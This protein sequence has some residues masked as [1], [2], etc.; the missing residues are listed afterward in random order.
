MSEYEHAA[1]LQECMKKG[2]VIMRPCLFPGHTGG[3]KG[4]SLSKC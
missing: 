1:L 4:T 3:N 2:D